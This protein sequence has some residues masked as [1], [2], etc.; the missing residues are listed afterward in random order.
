MRVENDCVFC[1]IVERRE[2]AHVVWQDDEH[3]AFLDINPITAGHVLLIPRIH[4]RWVDDLSP[5]A[6]ARLFARVRELTLPIAAAAGAPRT[7]IAVEGFGVAHAHVHLVPIWHLGDLDPHRQ[8]PASDADLR[9]A[10]AR[11]RSA[12]MQS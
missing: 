4:V 12:L 11:I 9:A 2:P 1:G 3:M 10:A 7:G 5:E 6:H 8:A